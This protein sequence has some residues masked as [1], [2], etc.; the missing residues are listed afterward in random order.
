MRYESILELKSEATQRLYHVARNRLKAHRLPLAPSSL[1]KFIHAEHRRGTTP[2]TIRVYV[3][4]LAGKLRHDK[5][6]VNTKQL[7]Y[8]RE[9]HPMPQSVSKSDIR[10]IL[11][12]SDPE[13]Q[14]QLLSLL[15]SGM[16]VSELAQI[17]PKMMQLPKVSIPPEITKTGRGRMTFFSPQVCRM[18][19]KRLKAGEEIFFGGRTPRQA[20]NLVDKRFATARDRADLMSKY[21]HTK[22]NRYHIHP[23]SL[24]AY[25]ITE[26]NKI[27]FG[28]GHI[29]AGHD[30]Y[31]KQY[32]QYTVA[33]LYTMYRKA[34]LEVRL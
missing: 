16:R 27:Q 30:F 26:L 2:Q 4:A 28:V 23:H 3:H 24:R 31:M 12:Q 17:T 7:V 14:F 5:K 1:Q 21:S 15:S 13:F 10:D 20:V 6:F 29:L 33:D 34:D 9:L 18:I 11:H 19:K 32:N 8:P 22:Q 25:F